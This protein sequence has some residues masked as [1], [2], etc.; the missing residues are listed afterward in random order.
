[1]AITLVIAGATAPA[2]AIALD[3]PRIVIGRGSHADVRLPSR[4][5]SDLH[6]V[7][8]AEG[9][10]VFLLDEGST[11]GTRVNGQLV[12][13]GRRKALKTGDAIG[14]AGYELR[15]E[16][17]TGVPDPPERTATLARRLLLGALAAAGGEAAPPALVVL[18]GRRGDVRFP[19]APPPSRVVVG[20]AEECDIVLDDRDA[21]RHHVEVL[22]DH[23]GA[24][25][26]D[27]GSKNGVLVAGRRLTERR[28][29]H[30]DEVV[31][32]R[33]PVRYEDP[34]EDLLRSFEGGVD[35]TAPEPPPP[36]APSLPPSEA[37]PPSPAVAVVDAG[38]VPPPASASL[39]PP[40]RPARTRRTADWI[41][42]ALAVV[43]LAV[44]LAALLLV[45]NGGP[46]R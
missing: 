3:Q 40:A 37:A 29:R 45:L 16:F 15:V 46:R 23:D 8:R 38:D 2:Q 11:N 31:I 42:V 35:E 33:T 27:L 12:P 36:A 14:I 22:R 4:A 43:I 5:V 17:T 21:S 18:G 25:L 41:V 19:L 30:G 13:R 6:A 39:P 28:L 7:I 32:G 44:S 10:E 20:R 26:R 24:L 1:M 34:L 9:S